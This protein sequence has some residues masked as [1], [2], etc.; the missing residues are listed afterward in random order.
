MTH[1][2]RF[3]G[4]YR[5]PLTTRDKARLWAI[6]IV[7]GFALSALFFNPLIKVIHL[8]IGVMWW[9]FGS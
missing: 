4:Q 5:S 9:V 1:I 8:I 6:G 2:G 7:V 3:G